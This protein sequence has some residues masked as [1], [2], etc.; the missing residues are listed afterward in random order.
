MSWQALRNL[1]RQFTLF[2]KR[3]LE[4][5]VEAVVKERIRV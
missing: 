4:K 5:Q 2:I 1:D 3:P